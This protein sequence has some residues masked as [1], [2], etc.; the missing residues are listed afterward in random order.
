MCY[1]IV[2]FGAGHN[3]TSCSF[4]RY[5]WQVI[6]YHIPCYCSQFDEQKVDKYIK[7]LTSKAPPS[8]I[9]VA[10]EAKKMKTSLLKAS[11]DQKLTISN[12]I[13]SIK[14]EQEL[15][16]AVLDVSKQE[17]LTSD[18]SMVKPP[19]KPPK[20]PLLPEERVALPKNP[21]PDPNP[22]QPDSDPPRAVRGVW[23]QGTIA[24]MVHLVK[25][26][27][28]RITQNVAYLSIPFMIQAN[29]ENLWE[30]KTV[31]ERYAKTFEDEWPE[32]V[33]KVKLGGNRQR[34]YSHL[35]PEEVVEKSR[36]AIAELKSAYS[37][38]K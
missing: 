24:Q 18:V 36:Q 25:E 31:V 5:I 23:P 33:S 11:L 8:S 16:Q 7:A 38:M 15:Q 14:C 17:V 26:Y 35:P 10:S 37:E 21:Q 27:N 29:V 4:D 32:T 28:H 13:L 2:I 6:T 1:R 22:P 3:I 9:D 30:L 20:K 19:A 12:K 34:R